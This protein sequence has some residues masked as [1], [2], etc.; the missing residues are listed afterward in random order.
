MLTKTKQTSDTDDTLWVTFSE[1][2]GGKEA[3][4]SEDSSTDLD[5]E[6]LVP[7]VFQVKGS[8]FED[9]YQQ[10]LKAVQDMIRMDK[11]ALRLGSFMNQT[12]LLTAM[13]LD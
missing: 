4:D 7:E 1:G 13:H 6:R 2:G 3:E 10:T 8:V 5:F 11:L 12:T 9:H